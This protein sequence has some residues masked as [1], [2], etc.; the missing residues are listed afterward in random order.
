MTD[1]DEREEAVKELLSA[2]PL[3]RHL[4]EPLGGGVEAPPP[5]AALRGGRR[6]PRHEPEEDVHPRRR[7]R[8]GVGAIGEAVLVVPQ[9][10]EAALGPHNVPAHD[11]CPVRALRAGRLQP[12]RYVSWLI[13]WDG[14]LG[15]LLPLSSLLVQDIPFHHKICLFNSPCL[16]F[17]VASEVTCRLHFR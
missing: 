2:G 4:E 15:V 17:R 16:I 9:E 1:E 12:G 10:E 14:G 7:S 5:V 8:L 13:F 3:H 11:R 6:E